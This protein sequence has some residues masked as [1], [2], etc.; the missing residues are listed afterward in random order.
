MYQKGTSY[1][2]TG[3]EMPLRN[4]RQAKNEVG[5]MYRIEAMPGTSFLARMYIP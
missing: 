5:V 2:F 4:F 1:L 3:Y